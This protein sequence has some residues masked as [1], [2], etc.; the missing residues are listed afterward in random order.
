MGFKIQNFKKLTKNFKNVFYNYFNG[1]YSVVF[2][3][4]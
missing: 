3:I 4:N 1:N 2:E